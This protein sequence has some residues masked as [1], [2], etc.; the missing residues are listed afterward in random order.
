MLREKK[1]HTQWEY[2]KLPVFVP[3]LAFAGTFDALPLYLQLHMHVCRAMRMDKVWLDNS[4]YKFMKRKTKRLSMLPRIR[5][6]LL[7]WSQPHTY[8]VCVCMGPPPIY[9]ST[10]AAHLYHEHKPILEALKLFYDAYAH[11]IEHDMH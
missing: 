9:A 10:A 7:H 11:C 6:M 1:T 5:A 8:W 4:Y 2:K 3:L